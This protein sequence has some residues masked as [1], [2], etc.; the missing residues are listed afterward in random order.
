MQPSLPGKAQA[1]LREV[2]PR[3]VLSPSL[4]LI[5]LFVYGFIIYTGYL[6]LTDSRMLPSYD[7]EGFGNYGV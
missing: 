1:T 3:L 2:L 4:F 7:L 5:L 6:S